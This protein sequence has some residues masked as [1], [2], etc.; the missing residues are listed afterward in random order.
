MLDMHSKMNSV[1]DNANLQ[2]EIVV[3][4]ASSSH[5]MACSNFFRLV[6]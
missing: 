6:P 1:G 4:Y 2:I 5:I 3:A